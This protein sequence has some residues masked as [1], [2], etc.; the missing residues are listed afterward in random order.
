MQPSQVHQTIGKYML[1]DSK[2][3]VF[4]MERSNG[5]YL[6]DAVTGKE[7]IDF[8]TF[9]ASNPIGYN[10]PGLQDPAF[11]E[12]L[13][14]SAL[15]KP[16]NS[17]IYTTLMA[18]F[19]DAFGRLA[20]PEEMPYL[21]LV[22]GGSLAVENALKTAFDWK[23]R[24]NFSAISGANLKEAMP[25][26]V[27]GL[28]SKVIH[29]EEAFHGRS[30][31]TLSMTNTDDPRKYMYFPKFDWPRVINPKLR[32]PINEDVLRE[33]ARMEEF[34]CAQIEA[35]VRQHKGD[36]AALI[37]ETIQ[38]EGGDN[39]FRTEFMRELRRLADEHEFLLIFDEV[40][41]G[42]GITG[43]MWAFEHHDVRPDIFAFGKKSQVSGIVVGKRIDEVSNHVFEEPSRINS[44][45]GGNLTDM[46]RCTRYLEIIAENDLLAHTAKMGQKM[47]GELQTV[48][49]ES[50]G[51]IT[52]VRGKGLMIAYDLPDQG[53]RDGMIEKMAGNGLQ[54]MKSGNRSIRFRGM[55]DTPE[56]VINEA[57]KIVAR[58]IPAR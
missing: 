32:F 25:A 24:K 41:A 28:G 2:H 52:N 7:Y 30:G 15:H 48:A 42:M 56:E 44:T 4:D 26:M 46:V 38:G 19:V 58:S 8:F 1:A 54:A 33:V 10:H 31:Y 22:S 39:H 29:F 13:T 34:A 45:F 3:I 51:V 5:A 20:M 55:L 57:V 53:K 27:E 40:Q 21:F 47:I 16:S 23:A 37:I 35:V 17:D 43:K 36:V 14:L 50:K 9:F 18:E 12:K 49:E 11:V 6:V